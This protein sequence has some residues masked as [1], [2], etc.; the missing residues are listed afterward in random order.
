VFC[1]SD[2]VKQPF[3]VALHAEP[4]SIGLVQESRSK[5]TWCRRFPVASRVFAGPEFS[6]RVSPTG[7]NVVII[8]FSPVQVAVGPCDTSRLALVFAPLRHD[9][10]Q[11]T[12]SAAITAFMRRTAALRKKHKQY[13]RLQNQIEPKIVPAHTEK[14]AAEISGQGSYGR[15][16]SQS[17]SAWYVAEQDAVA[18]RE[19]LTSAREPG[20]AALW[21]SSP[22]SAGPF[23][24]KTF[25]SR[26]LGQ[27]FVENNKGA[28]ASSSVSSGTSVETSVEAA[29]GSFTW[30]SNEDEIDLRQVFGRDYI[31]E[32]SVNLDPGCQG[33]VT[34]HSRDTHGNTAL[35]LAAWRGDRLACHW[36]VSNGADV[37]ALNADGR[38]SR[39][40][41]CIDPLV[42]RAAS[43]YPNLVTRPPPPPPLLNIN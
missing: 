42:L 8:C 36:L 13:R 35:H 11:V 26:P 24:Q 40:S 20:A 38:R 23:E 16:C 32:L 9:S 34:V 14:F 27:L 37:F 22:R 28:P 31:E 3:C 39:C 10:F 5:E 2:C 17:F 1:R 33:K 41:S 15:A 12:A 29:V 43:L 7:H 4:R 21:H 18:R 6:T 30:T 19:N 25:E